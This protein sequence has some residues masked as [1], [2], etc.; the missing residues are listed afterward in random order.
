[1]CVC[2]EYHS[3]SKFS[4]ILVPEHRIMK[5]NPLLQPPVESVHIFAMCMLFFVI[6]FFVYA[7]RYWECALSRCFCLVCAEPFSVCNRSIYAIKP[8]VLEL[9]CAVCF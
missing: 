8:N 3:Y 2:V 9:C 5:I 1:M 7:A 4:R 6:S